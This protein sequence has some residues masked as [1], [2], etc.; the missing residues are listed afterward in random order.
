MANNLASC[1]LNICS[2]S[3]LSSSSVDDESSSSS[4]SSS[5]G[6]SN[7]ITEGGG[8]RI[9]DDITDTTTI[10]TSKSTDSN[11]NNGVVVIGGISYKLPQQ[12]KKN[13]SN[14][15]IDQH[16]HIQYSPSLSERNNL[17]SSSHIL[18]TILPNNTIQQLQ[19]LQ[20]FREQQKK[21]SKP[22]SISSSSSSS[23]S[24]T[25]SSPSILLSF[26][27]PT[28]ST[29]SRKKHY[30]KESTDDNN[31]Q[32]FNSQLNKNNEDD[33]E[34]EYNDEDE[35][36]NVYSDED[37]N[38]N[39]SNEDGSENEND[40]ENEK[41]KLDKHRQ[42]YNEEYYDRYIDLQQ[43]QF[44]HEHEQE[45]LQQQQKS[46]RK[47]KKQRGSSYRNDDNVSQFYESTA[48]VDGYE[49]EG[50]MGMG[51]GEG[52]EESEE[53][54]AA[55]REREREEREREE[56]EIYLQRRVL[57]ARYTDDIQEKNE[58]RDFMWAIESEHR[59]RERWYPILAP[60]QKQIEKLLLEDEPIIPVRCFGCRFERVEK[61]SSIKI[62]HDMWQILRNEFVKGMINN[63]G[64]LYYLGGTLYEIFESTV[65]K[66]IRK[67]VG[68]TTKVYPQ[69]KDQLDTINTEGQ[70][71]NQIWTPYCLMHHFL[72]HSSE[73]SIRHCLNIYRV[74]TV[75][76][77]IYNEGMFLENSRSGRQDVGFD[78]L[79]KFKMALELEYAIAS[80]D[81]S[82]LAFST[83]TT[84]GSST[85][86]P[87]N[88][89]YTYLS[90]SVPSFSPKDNPLH[91]NARKRTWNA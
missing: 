8:D 33:D 84:G 27:T 18:S 14:I 89:H 10:I 44:Q 30:D 66:Q 31:E 69:H 7:E 6:K 3:N 86:I 2:S 29:Y 47:G 41:S 5:L 77:T 23:S 91:K 42:K 39:Y 63:S 19:T 73:P 82:K 76:D 88:P 80:K 83:S 52:E 71:T 65:V 28:L 54:K 25:L 16:N 81:P 37:E 38:E 59:L 48:G 79:R 68:D 74:R 21:I 51:M 24:S 78:G 12:N 75:T 35:N 45:L 46:K 15:L 17:S 34:E 26:Q 13:L 11:N 62:N 50:G 55:R 1:D 72:S 4:S 61:N 36:D 70:K 40:I 9:R 53:S 90:S 87:S 32:Q 64:A 67:F 58:P 60:I 22:S 56:R 43:R 49:G 57:Q 85:G 20:Q